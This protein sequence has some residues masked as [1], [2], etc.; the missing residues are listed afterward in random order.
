[1]T[2][3]GSLCGL[4]TGLLLGGLWGIWFATLGA[5]M[6]PLAFDGV[7]RTIFVWV[8]VLHGFYGLLTGFTLARAGA[9]SDAKNSA[10]LAALTTAVLSYLCSSPLTA[11][12][13]AAYGAFFGFACYF[14]TYS[15]ARR[16][17]G[18]E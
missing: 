16:T 1:M 11:L 14:V 9:L 10:F 4:L 2:F 7:A 12:L 6:L 3:Y 13:G 15:M 17:E 8:L 18:L 5:S